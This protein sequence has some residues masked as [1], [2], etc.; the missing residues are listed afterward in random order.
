MNHVTT[1]WC[2]IRK[3]RLRPLDRLLS[4]LADSSTSAMP[5][6]RHADVA[7]MHL[8]QDCDGCDV[9]ARAASADTGHVGASLRLVEAGGLRYS[10]SAGVPPSL[11]QDQG[12]PVT[13]ALRRLGEACGATYYKP[14][15]S[16]LTQAGGD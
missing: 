4:A 16:S 7:E 3:S 11:G 6:A 1:L 5:A 12:V 13:G 2:G 9:L 15:L 14:R 10:W 8:K